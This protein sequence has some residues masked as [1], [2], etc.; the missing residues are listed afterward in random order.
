MHQSLSGF[1]KMICLRIP[2][3]IRRGRTMKLESSP[4][5]AVVVREGEDVVFCDFEGDLGSEESLKEFRFSSVNYDSV[6][7]K[8]VNEANGYKGRT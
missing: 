1:L 3:S 6:I 5:V 4:C 2:H 7:S 8:I